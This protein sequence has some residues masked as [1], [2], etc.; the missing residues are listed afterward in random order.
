MGTANTIAEAKKDDAWKAAIQSAIDQT[1]SNPVICASPPWKVQKWV[2]L[3][4]DF[5][6]ETG[7]L[8]ATLKL[9]RSEACKHFA[10]EIDALYG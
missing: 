7:E 6:V 8:T 4:R 9:K 10:N 2:I 1:N 5:S 3:D